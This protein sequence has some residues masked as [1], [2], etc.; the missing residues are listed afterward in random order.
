MQNSGGFLCVVE[1]VKAQKDDDQ[2]CKVAMANSAK[3]ACQ[4]CE[5]GRICNLAAFAEGQ[6]GEVD[7]PR[8]IYR[9]LQKYGT[10]RKV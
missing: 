8:N 10:P 5:V 3:L 4:L 1:G 7:Q 2:L 6:L 9:Y